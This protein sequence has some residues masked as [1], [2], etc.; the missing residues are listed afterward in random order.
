MHLQLSDPVPELVHR[1]VV[2]EIAL[3]VFL[4]ELRVVKGAESCRQTPECSNKT[5]DPVDRVNA[6]TELRLPRK[7]EAVFRLTLHRNQRISRRGELGD[8]TNT[9]VHRVCEVA[10]SIRNLEGLRL[11]VTAIREGF[12]PGHDHARETDIGGSLEA[13]QA[14][15]FDQ[16]VAELSESKRILVIAESMSCHVAEPNIN[17]ARTV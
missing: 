13:F 1:R 16:I 3:E 14:A 17:E 2:V 5:Q 11:H 6:K 12:H 15:L 9:G 7:V 4:V 10:D 8:Q